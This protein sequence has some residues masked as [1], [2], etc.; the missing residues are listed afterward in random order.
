MTREEKHQR[1]ASILE[2]RNSGMKMDDIASAMG[3]TGSSI[4]SICKRMGAKQFTVKAERTYS[5]PKGNKHPNWHTEEEVAEIVSRH[6]PTFEYVGNYTG[7]EGRA[8]IRCKICGD[9]TN[10][11]MRSVRHSAVMC[12]NCQRLQTEAKNKQRAEEKQRLKEEQ[13]RQRAEQRKAKV[14]PVLTKVCVECGNTFQTTNNKKVCCSSECTKHRSNNKHDRRLKK[15]GQKDNG[16]TLKAL[17]KRDNGICYLCGK[18]CDWNDKTINNRGTIT[19]D[20]YPSIDHI[21]PLSLGGVNE[22]DNVR[23]ACRRCNTKKNN[24]SAIKMLKDGRLAI[25]F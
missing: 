16:I 22:W 4:S 19:G 5:T 2:M 17:F 18:Q 7:I 14:K 21:I 13:E 6:L 24:K 12:R 10:R 25:N 1:W 15:Y 11:S 3:M 23:L 20:D 8:D 9:V